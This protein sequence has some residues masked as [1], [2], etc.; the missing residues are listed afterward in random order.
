MILFVQLLIR[1]PNSSVGAVPVLQKGNY[2]VRQLLQQC[3]L[4][5]AEI[6]G[7]K[8]RTDQEQLWSC[9]ASPQTLQSCRDR[10]LGRVTFAGTRSAQPQIQPRAPFQ[11]FVSF[12]GMGEKLKCRAL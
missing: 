3:P 5:G 9:T 12:L 10:A 4:F 2:C 8:P 7:D 6:S 1:T 11:I